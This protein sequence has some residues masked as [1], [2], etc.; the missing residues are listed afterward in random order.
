MLDWIRG[1]I[2]M[3]LMPWRGRRR[4]PAPFSQLVLHLAILPACPKLPQARPPLTRWPQRWNPFS[5]WR[6][7]KVHW[8]RWKAAQ[9]GEPSRSWVTIFD[10]AAGITPPGADPRGGTKGSGTADPQS[11]T[12][13]HDLL[14]DLPKGLGGLSGKA[15]CP[16]TT[17]LNIES[18]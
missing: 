16:L 15:M 12:L 18:H 17:L 3:Q 11:F 13:D 5:H 10:V 2:V 1:I 9:R 7:E 14:N 4:R 6:P 8:P